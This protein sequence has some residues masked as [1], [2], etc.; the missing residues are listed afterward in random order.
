MYKK[1]SNFLIRQTM[2]SE[3]ENVKEKKILATLFEQWIMSTK[4]HNQT[5]I[6]IISLLFT[7]YKS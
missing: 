3:W 4:Y 2:T 5:L 7:L 1:N 6:K